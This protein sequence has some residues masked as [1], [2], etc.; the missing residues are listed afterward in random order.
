MKTM[1]FSSSLLVVCLSMQLQVNAQKRGEADSFTI[2]EKNTTTPILISDDEAKVVSIAADL[3]AG[4]VKKITD[5]QP[6]V[7]NE[8]PE[9]ARELIIAGTIGQNA[10]IDQL[11]ADKKINVSAIA[12]KWE[13]WS[14]QVLSKPFP[15]VKKA[16]VI[17]GSDRRA[18]AYGI[19]ELS[20]MMGVSAWEWW[21]D[22]TPAK[23]NEITLDI[24]P[25]T[26]GSPSVKY[27]GLFLNDED[28]GLQPWA[29]KTFEP[30]TGDIGPKTYAKIFE[31]ML[32]LRA[33]TI[34]PA[35]HGCTKAFYTIAGNAQTA[36]DYAIV[37]GTSH[38]EPMLCNINAE[39]DHNTMGEWRYDNNV[40]TI[41]DLFEKRTKA[42]SNFESIY[43]IGMRGEHDS[44]MNAKDLTKEDQ[45]NLLE[46]VIADQREIM[47]KET[48]KDPRTLPQAFIPYKEVLDYYQNGLEVPEDV[49]LMWTDDNYGYIRQLSTPEEQ[50]RPGGG[51]IYYHVSYWGRPHDYLWLSS[52]NPMLIWEEMYKAYQFN[53]RDMW[54]LN[55]GDIKPLEYNIELFMDMAWDIDEF[56]GT[57]DVQYHL[58]DWLSFLFGVEKAPQLTK[59]MMDYYHLCFMRRPEFMAWS[60]TEPTTKPQETELAQIRY[61]DELTKRL[62]AWEELAKEVKSLDENIPADKKD[63]FFELVYY[64]VTGASLMNQKWLYHYKNELAARQ[65]RTSA[66]EFAARSKAAF[67]QIKKETE[68]F[69]NKLQ[70]GKWKNMMSMSPRNLPVFSK[71]SYALPAGDGNVELG[72][73]LEGYEME[74]NRQI[75]NNYADVLPVLNAYL[76]DSAFVDVFLKGEGEV[77]W[78]AEPKQPWI[79]LSADHGMLTTA[80]GEQEKRLWVSI[81]WDQVLQG[82][83]TK[84]PPLGH[85]YQLIPPA[86]KV[87]GAIEFSSKDTTITIGVSTYNPKFAALDNFEGFVEASGYVSINAEN[88]SSRVAGKEAYWKQFGGLGYSGNVIVAL[89]YDA[90]PITDPAAIKKQSPML[91]YDFYTFNFGEADVRVQAVP[92]HPFY[93]GGGVRCAVAIDDAKPVILDFQTFGRSEEWKQNV[94]KNATVKSAK[95]M[96]AEPG[97][98]KLKV[99]MVDPGVMIDQILIDLGGWKKSYA[100]PPQTWK[101]Q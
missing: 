80:D 89:P 40:A 82:E 86:Y 18:A 15:G 62:Q 23:R 6:E 64:P 11:I 52:T 44:P 70:N 39:W 90:E 72:L 26:Y 92:T 60:Q 41:R 77:E 9:S 95:Q 56:A 75:E 85:D 17:V 55:C 24:E 14:M 22:V 16:L 37:V 21:A 50:K 61:G 88:T 47:Q 66:Q 98:H 93:D 28:W 5:Q 12:G 91:E 49:T 30:E 48:G 54:I 57:T 67:D 59:L 27:R 87:N 45:I 58:N 29:A 101:Q 100:F 81:D 35:M 53:C 74:A 76:K 99:W 78:K 19:L 97:E 42:T 34:W 65:G 63:A 73:A 2:S 31:L 84:E 69:N 51:G 38:C 36:D 20:R 1:I 32:R 25:K 33:N 4:D 94:L 8:L 3:Y 10:I 46:K 7:I 83:N 79:R 43:T 68:Y 96:I 13:S 71:P